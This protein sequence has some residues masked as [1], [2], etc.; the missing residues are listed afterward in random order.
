MAGRVELET[1]T[2]PQPVY[3]TRGSGAFRILVLGDLGGRASRGVL[4]YGDGLAER[5]LAS[6]D[7]DEFDATLFRFA[8]R[9]HL[10]VSRDATSG[11]AVEFKCLEDFHPDNLF[12]GLDLF[13][14]LR[15]RRARLVDP[16]TFA[17]AAAE[18]RLSAGKTLS[19]EA[20]EGGS[21]TPVEDDSSTLERLLG[22]RPARPSA[23]G[24]APATR[25]D[26]DGI[27]RHIVEPHIVAGT[28]PQQAQLV[29]AV[30]AGIGDQMRALLHDGAFQ[31][32]EAVWRSVHDLVTRLETGEDLELYLL[33]VSKEELAADVAAAGYD[34]R[35]SGLW[36]RVVERESGTPGGRVWSLLVGA[37]TFGPGTADVDLLGALG[38]IAG[39]AGAPF[40]AAADP[41][42]LGCESLGDFPEPRDWRSPQEDDERWLA[43]R[44]SPAG[45]WIG[46]VLPRLLLRLPYGTGGEEI[47]RFEFEELGS[48]PDHAAFLWG[49]GAFGCARLIARAFLERGWSMEPGDVSDLDDLPAY[50]Y[51]EGDERR[52]KPCAEVLLS[53]R[54]GSAILE[55]GVMP[56]LSYRDRNAARLLRFQTVAEPSTA[57]PGPWSAS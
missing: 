48:R 15:R 55:R 47:D 44:R 56:L 36:R 22:K 6:V 20:A 51:E 9:L 50:V 14:E 41:A 39:E 19:S 33:D 3:R 10:P 16:A 4:E 18:L 26:L 40:L 32:L 21:A 54:S 25:L 57:L 27:I 31:E 35:R 12:D 52:L 24:P 13:R 29:A 42:I 43:L 2:R 37:Y 8:P 11:M 30:D 53:E 5:P 49:N 45:S 7:V 38:R 23:A 46:L 17:Q 1:A 34:P 28:D